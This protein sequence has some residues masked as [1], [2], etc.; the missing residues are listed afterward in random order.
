RPRRWLAL[1][2]SSL[3]LARVILGGHQRRLVTLLERSLKPR[4]LRARHGL[5]KG[6]EQTQDGLREGEA[7]TRWMKEAVD[8]PAHSLARAR[9]DER[10]AL[11]R[12]AGDGVGQHLGVL[13][14][15]DL[16]AR[17]LR[18]GQLEQ[19][20]G[21]RWDLAGIDAPRDDVVEVLPYR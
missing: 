19:R 2:R 13:D 11:V 10:E 15:G 21:A 8:Q 16:E 7:F 4:V 1:G 3:R 5:A 6:G 9:G 20:W 17:P 18:R 12:G 14:T